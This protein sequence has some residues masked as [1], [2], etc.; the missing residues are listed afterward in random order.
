MSEFYEVQGSGKKSYKVTINYASGH[1]CK[2]R[3][4]ISKKGTYNEDAGKTSGTS[5]KHINKIINEKYA[6]DWGTKRKD[7]SRSPVN[8][9]A[10]VRTGPTD[11]MAAVLAT[12]ARQE[13][14]GPSETSD[15]P[16]GT[17]LLDRIAGLES[18][19]SGV[20]N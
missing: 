13:S 20:S 12:R 1:W 7:G 9:Q 16:D 14:A 2:C 5:C 18:A 3:G 15:V 11:R 17:S 8:A 6:G 10:T 19:K 4:M